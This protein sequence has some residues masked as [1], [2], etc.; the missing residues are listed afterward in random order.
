MFRTMIMA[1]ALA[2]LFAAPQ[3]S[4]QGLLGALRAKAE[5]TLS[6]AVR[7]GQLPSLPGTRSLSSGSQS[8]SGGGFQRYGNWD[9]R[10]DTLELGADEQWQAVVTVRNP[11]AHRQGLVA[12]EISLFL[13]TEDGETL[14][15][16][17]ELYKAGVEGSSAGLE[18]APGTMWLERGD[19]MRIRLR[20]DGSRGMKPA[21]LRIQSTGATAQ[22]RTF[23]VSY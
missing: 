9:F 14:E 12:S 3:A 1:S 10:F 15:N 17:G 13:I 19:A 6:D 18:P 21:K 16:W 20:F 8:T 11:E 5:Q 22:A 2:A 7:T 4:A 23:P